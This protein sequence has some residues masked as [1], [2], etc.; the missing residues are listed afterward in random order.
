MIVRLPVLVH[1]LLRNILGVGYLLVHCICSH[2]YDMTV[3]II[4][5]KVDNI[6]Q[7]LYIVLTESK[8]T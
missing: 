3:V 5:A 8:K 2:L 4:F 7:D 6:S 1:F